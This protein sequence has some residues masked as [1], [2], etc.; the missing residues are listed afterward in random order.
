MARLACRWCGT[1]PTGRT[2]WPKAWLL[3]CE[4]EPWKDVSAPP[5][6][7]CRCLPRGDR[8][9][10]LPGS[11]Y[12]AE[13]AEK[14]ED[15][16]GVAFYDPERPGPSVGRAYLMTPDQFEDVLAQENGFEPG[17]R[18]G[19]DLE[20]VPAKGSRWGKSWYDLVLP[21]DEIGGWRAFTIT[22]SKARS[23]NRPEAPYLRVVARGL[24][25]AR[26]WALDT[27]LTYLLG[28]TGISRR[29]DQAAL[30]DAIA[31]S[32]GRRSAP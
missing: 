32:L 30:A 16:G 4:G 21:L 10:T 7:R 24:G 20:G 25:E 23:P 18:H 3:T 9:Y 11:V 27:I 17:G 12:F 29:W 13:N 14:C 5:G 22:T 31:S 1:C 19:V 15:G 8:C 2:Y 6:A 26:G 28:L